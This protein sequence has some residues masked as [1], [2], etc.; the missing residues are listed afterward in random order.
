MNYSKSDSIL[1]KACTE[2]ADY[3]IKLSS[4][5]IIRFKECGRINKHFIYIPYKYIIFEDDYKNPS[6]TNIN[7]NDNIFHE[8]C[9]ID[10]NIAN[11]VFIIENNI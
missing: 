11:I 7:I 2:Y 10:I 3:T 6:C 5:D 8:T 1:E 4:G 9:G